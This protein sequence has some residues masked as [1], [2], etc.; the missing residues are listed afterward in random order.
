MTGI[1]TANDLM[2]G[3]G[4]SS[5]DTVT[6]SKRLTDAQ[7]SI[8]QNPGTVAGILQQSPIFPPPPA[9]DEA[10]GTDA[11]QSAL[12]ANAD[13]ATASAQPAAGASPEPEASGATPAAP[14]AS[15]ADWDQPGE[16]MMPATCGSLGS[17]VAL[18]QAGLGGFAPQEPRALRQ[19]G[20]P[21]S[22]PEETTALGRIACARCL[23]QRPI[24]PADMDALDPERV[25]AIIA[26]W[27]SQSLRRGQRE[28]HGAGL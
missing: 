16:T 26:S 14:L 27:D 20:V 17:S 24:V 22:Q 15:A 2:K 25:D 13:S 6:A 11:L 23:R 4:T 21:R 9:N 5:V 18:D 3:H 1:T 12:V 8:A 7:I 28:S 19:L 10:L